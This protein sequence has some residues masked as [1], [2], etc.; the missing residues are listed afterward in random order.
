M[1]PAFCRR[2]LLAV[3]YGVGL[4]SC[5]GGATGPG[6][7][8]PAVV[9]PAQ[10]LS[11]ATM[12]LG[13][14]A[15]P[16]TFTVDG[17]TSSL[18][19]P[20]ASA[21]LGSTLSLSVAKARGIHTE[22]IG[23]SCSPYTPPT[24][25]ITNPTRWP[26]VI[27]S[28]DL[29]YAYILILTQCNVVGNGYNVA[30]AQ[31]A[32]STTSPTTIGDVKGV[33]ITPNIYALS[34]FEARTGASYTFAPHSTSA[35][36]FEQATVDP[37]TGYPYPNSQVVSIAPNTPVTLGSVPTE[38]CAGSGTASPSPGCP[39]GSSTQT[40]VG[41][42]AQ[43][44][45]GGN[46]SVDCFNT[47]DP[48]FSA[49]SQ[50]NIAAFP[51]VVKGACEFNTG[52]S[53]ITVGT[54]VTFTITN[55]DPDT[56]HGLLEGP[57]VQ[58]WC[59]Q[60][61]SGNTITATCPTT[62]ANGSGFTIGTDSST[63]YEYFLFGN[64]PGPPA[65][66]TLSPSWISVVAGT[67]SNGYTFSLPTFATYP[68]TM[69]IDGD[70][71]GNLSMAESNPT[72]CTP[73]GSQNDMTQ[74]APGT[75]RVNCN[76]GHAQGIVVSYSGNAWQY[77]HNG[78]AGQN[79]D[80]D[81]SCVAYAAIDLYDATGTNLIQG[82]GPGATIN[83]TSTALA[84]INPLAIVDPVSGALEDANG[85]TIDLPLADADPTGNTAT[86]VKVTE[87]NINALNATSVTFG[88]RQPTNG[89]EFGLNIYYDGSSF[90]TSGSPAL[91]VGNTGGLAHLPYGVGL[92]IQANALGGDGEFF[93][94]PPEPAGQHAPPAGLIW[95]WIPQADSPEAV[96][97]RT[98]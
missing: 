65:N 83:G 44:S 59:T 98:L 88:L 78:V 31:I 38:S 97:R 50:A 9:Q 26:I 77:Q 2:I 20:S 29:Q 14:S 60:V 36:T 11:S 51:G 17:Q 93:I 39:N 92:N 80:C 75:I 61:T 5:S 18:A 96:R 85:E 95:I 8:A 49:I 10:P 53:T 57:P 32:P 64:D 58:V 22:S 72:P 94:S 16:A 48:R 67:A 19:L 81:A 73:G 15:K 33:K 84:T 89:A 24:I 52:S 66:V 47:Q 30:L 71:N 37:S 82:D 56:A 1:S 42:M 34:A 68:V 69:K 7:S 55:P 70:V 62:G 41:L 87:A 90:V 21:P 43:T 45:S 28:R 46:A 27:S 13:Q 91:P 25:D 6:P 40:S 23:S 4:A 54:T 79:Q 3:A 86:V 63:Q 12:S 35:L 76:S 74:V